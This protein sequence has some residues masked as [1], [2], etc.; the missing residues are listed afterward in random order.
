MSEK[1]GSGKT[2][3]TIRQL[4]LAVALAACGGATSKPTV[5]GESHF[6]A[7][8]TTSCEGGLECVSGI[9]TRDCVVDSSSCADLSPRAKC[10]NQS[11]EPGEL[12]VCD[13]SCERDGDCAALGEDFACPSGFCRIA[14]PETPPAQTGTAGAPAT[15]RFAPECAEPLSFTSECSFEATCEQLG[16]GDGLSAF[17]A[18]GCT[19][20]CQTSDDCGAGQ[21]CRH[22]LLYVTDDD[23]PF[24]G[25]EVEDCTLSGGNCSCSTSADCPHPDVCVDAEQYPEALDCMVE[26]ASCAALQT[27]K[28]ALTERDRSGESAEKSA[29]ANDCLGK[30][31][32]KQRAQGCNVGLPTTCADSFGFTNECSFAQVCEQLHCGDGFSQFDSNGCLRYCQ[33]S[34]DCASGAR[35]LDTVLSLTE[36]DCPSIG[37]EVE[38]CYLVDGSCACSITEDCR[39]PRICVDSAAFPESADCNVTDA[40]C[41][42]LE[43]SVPWLEPVSMQSNPNGPVAAACLNKVQA[44]LARRDCP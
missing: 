36:Q 1:S 31:E 30:L 27:T 16:C 2:R 40:S 39:R 44:E 6:L 8:C 21:R 42:A 18:Q 5:G 22:T 29:T 37:S 23:C 20:H 38:G 17:D 26:G 33:T 11:V 14:G 34:Q 24:S 10:T 25:S 41:Q 12:A 19:R 35:C 15:D 4:L 43:A 32:A 13:L 9:C 7:S 28:F 3:R